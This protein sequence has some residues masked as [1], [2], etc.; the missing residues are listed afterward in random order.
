MRK[1]LLIPLAL[2]ALPTLSPAQ[3]FDDLATV[4]VLPGWRE[5][6]GDHIAGLRITLR[7]GW[8]TYWRAPGEAGIP[9]QFA[10]S[11]SADI[12]GIHPY[13]PTPD[14]IVDKGVRSI[15]YYD[16]VVVPLRIEAATDGGDLTLQGELQIGVCEE[17]C[18]PV[19]LDFATILPATGAMDASI[20]A[21]LEAGPK[22]QE[23]ADV[24]SVNCTI[25]PIS[26]GIRL[27][28]DIAVPTT[29]ASEH[30]V[31]EASDPSVWVSEADVTRSGASLQATVD[32]V[33]PSGGP[34]AVDRSGLRLTIFGGARAID[35][36]GC[37]PG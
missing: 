5:A 19:T 30:V 26:D 29:G 12:D 34:F 14:V 35:V 11:G 33:H 22:T 15:G 4:D 3:N 28:A 32:M 2:M 24:T 1:N 25:D 23:E 6:G 17:I 37:S 27:M 10:F 36:Q 13:W 16:T 7:P 8:I 20:V 9:P 31:I 18:I 21:A